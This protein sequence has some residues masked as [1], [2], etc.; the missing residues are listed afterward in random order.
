MRGA[1]RELWQVREVSAGRLP[2]P[3]DSLRPGGSRVLLGLAQ[4]PEPG[5]PHKPTHPPDP[6]AALWRGPGPP[7]AMGEGA[8][9]R[10]ELGSDPALT[11]GW[12]L[13]LTARPDPGHVLAAPALSHAP[14][15]SL[16]APIE[17]LG[18]FPPPPLSPLSPH[19]KGD[20]DRPGGPLR[21]QDENAG[22]AGVRP[23]RGRPLGSHCPPRYPHAGGGKQGV[24]PC[25]SFPQRCLLFL[26]GP[27]GRTEHLRSPEECV[28]GFLS[29]DWV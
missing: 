7:A 23:T 20:A 29:P 4:K 21:D 16:L 27:R 24:Q 3:V 9:P 12:A 13:P 11:P 2:R 17:R 8:A 18:L 10:A 28:P 14:L 25:T 5:P 1:E 26:S 22:R 6:P 15:L 19:G